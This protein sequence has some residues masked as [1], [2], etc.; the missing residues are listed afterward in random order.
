R[1]LFCVR[2][3][4]VPLQGA[5]TRRTAF[6]EELTEPERALV[7]E[8]AGPEQRIVVTGERD[9]RATAEVAHE[10][11]FTAW[12]SPR[13]WIAA[14]RAFY[15]W[16]TQNEADRKDWDD[17][18]KVSSALLTGRPL[19]RAKNFLE[20]DGDDVPPGA[21][22]DFIEASIKADKEMRRHA[23]TRSILLLAAIP[24]VSL[25]AWLLFFPPNV[26]IPGLIVTD[27][28][29]VLDLSGWRYMS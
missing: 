13:N 2:L 20:T 12:Q 14:R 7:L 28:E 29:T 11:L 3:A 22:R 4:Y 25:V 23:L 26:L 10:A 8:L 27:R 5:A 16:K 18:G 1:R 24:V 21:D 19:Q 6:L 15:A 9:G 17:Q